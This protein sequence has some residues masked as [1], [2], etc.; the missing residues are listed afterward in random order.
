ML[1]DL[2]TDIIYSV[3]LS[4]PLSGTDDDECSLR[5]TESFEEQIIPKDKY[6]STFSGQMEAI[7]FIIL[8]NIDRTLSAL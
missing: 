3:P 4:A 5:K 7:V 1:E 6:P 2:S 8:Y